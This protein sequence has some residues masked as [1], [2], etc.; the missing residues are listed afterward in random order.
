MKEAVM[1]LFPDAAQTYVVWA[2][3]ESS[4]EMPEEH[5]GWIVQPL[6]HIDNATIISAHQYCAC[7]IYP[8]R[9]CDRYLFKSVRHLKEYVDSLGVPWEWVTVMQ[10]RWQVVDTRI[11]VLDEG[12]AEAL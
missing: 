9:T 4:P 10:A 2:T 12:A 11:P 5:R 8:N 7:I 1:A 3:I 6:A